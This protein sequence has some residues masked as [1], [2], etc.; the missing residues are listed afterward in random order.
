[1]D[2]VTLLRSHLAELSESDRAFAQSLLDQAE[3]RG[4]SPKQLDW[5]GRLA[6]RA[7]EP[8]SKAIMLK[9][10]VAFME[11]AAV[12]VA[13]PH[14]TLRAADLDIRLSIAG[15]KSR[16]PGMINVT[17]ADRSY[18]ERI[19][20]GRIGFDGKFQP[21]LSPDQETQTAIVACLNALDANPTEAV[22][23]YGKLTGHCS[24]CDL[25]LS[26][27]RSLAVGYG[28]ICARKFG[29]PWNGGIV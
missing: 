4:L 6:G 16:T 29:L 11:H 14:L 18:D 10:I 20:Y 5:V 13:R 26:D 1:M 27:I 21:S 24:F 23:A 17:S 22:A 15:P 2:S 12:L 3:R 7:T 19:F 28:R 25:P 8:R 9:G